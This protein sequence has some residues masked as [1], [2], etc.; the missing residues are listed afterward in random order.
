VVVFA[1]LDLVG[2]CDRAVN[3]EPHVAEGASEGGGHADHE[4]G[5]AGEWGASG[6]RLGGGCD[7]R[8][9][10]VGCPPY[11]DGADKHLGS[12][13]SGLDV[14][15]GFLDA[16]IRVSV[17]GHAESRGDIDIAVGETHSVTSGVFVAS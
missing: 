16:E 5:V 7:R 4:F 10:V 2:G 8:E 15:A 14:V 9:R 11:G 1:G 12:V 17:E 13:G 6:V 3:A